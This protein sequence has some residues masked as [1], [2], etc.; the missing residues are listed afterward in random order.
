MVERVALPEEAV[1]IIEKGRRRPLKR[2]EAEALAPWWWSYS[3][4]FASMKRWKLNRF[5][6]DQSEHLAAELQRALDFIERAADSLPRTPDDLFRAGCVLEDL[7]VWVTAHRKHDKAGAHP[8]PVSVVAARMALFLHEEGAA[9]GL[10]KEGLPRRTACWL[11]ALCATSALGEEVTL[12]QV[13]K[14]LRRLEQ[15]KT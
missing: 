3:A 10:L 11:A 2:T 12:D 5:T 8:N 13:S 14:A 4:R 7:A 6:D 1:D 9:R 15:T